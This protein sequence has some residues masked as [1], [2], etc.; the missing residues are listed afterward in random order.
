MLHNRL[1]DGELCSM[2]F[3]T[4]KRGRVV[5][6][7]HQIMVLFTH[8]FDVHSSHLYIY[9]GL[10]VYICIHLLRHGAYESLCLT[11]FNATKHFLVVTSW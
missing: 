2:F 4:A 8:P 11:R 9:A 5:T 1:F 3:F 10:I 7:Q 6:K